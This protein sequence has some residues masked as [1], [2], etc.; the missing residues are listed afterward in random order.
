MDVS[1]VLNDEHLL[2]IKVH[3]RYQTAKSSYAMNNSRIN[4]NLFKNANYLQ[5]KRKLT[6][7]KTV[8]NRIEFQPSTNQVVLTTYIIC[9]RSDAFRQRITFYSSKVN[10]ATN[11]LYFILPRDP[12]MLFY[13]ISI[14]CE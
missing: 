6:A 3:H 1:S 4:T 8:L 11:K 2:V 7:H 13:G 12:R 5:H 14:V 9:K 10:N